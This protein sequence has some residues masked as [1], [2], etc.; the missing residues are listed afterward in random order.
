[1]VYVRKI[2]LFQKNIYIS[3]K[4]GYY[5]GNRSKPVRKKENK[6]RSKASLE[7]WKLGVWTLLDGLSR[8]R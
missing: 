4:R 6:G 5:E 1:M 2:I 3:L 8:A 7:G